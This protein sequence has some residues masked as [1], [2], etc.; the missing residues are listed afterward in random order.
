MHSLPELAIIIKCK[1][2]DGAYADHLVQDLL[3][4]QRFLHF[5]ASF[6]RQ[7]GGHVVMG[8]HNV[9]TINVIE[10]VHDPKNG[11]QSHVNFSH[12][13]SLCLCVWHIV[14]QCLGDLNFFLRRSGFGEPRSGLYMGNEVLYICH[15]WNSSSGYRDK[16]ILGTR[17]ERIMNF[18]EKSEQLP[19]IFIE[20]CTTPAKPAIPQINSPTYAMSGEGMLEFHHGAR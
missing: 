2:A 11:H 19:Q 14:P 15:N 3:P 17:K 5:P 7:A 10:H 20:Y 8:T 13:L 16:G 6:V 4:C 9:C 12:K 1:W 18:R